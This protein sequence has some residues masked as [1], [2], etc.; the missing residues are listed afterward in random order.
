MVRGLMANRKASIGSKMTAMLLLLS[1]LASFCSCSILGDIRGDTDGSR[2]YSSE[3]SKPEG[4]QTE[5]SETTYETMEPTGTYII[6]TTEPVEV[7]VSYVQ[8]VYLTS[9]W[10]D[11]VDD[12][13]I[14]YDYINSEDAFALKGV[15]Y[16]NTPLNCVFQAY[17]YKDDE[18]LL[19]RYV[20]MND[21][22]I[23]EA[24]FSAGLEGLGTFEPG[25]YYVQL[26]LDGE[27]VASTTTMTVR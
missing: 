12:N 25:H 9:T 16:F 17:L 4:N 11:V 5:T 10:Y 27:Y 19:T 14:N 8:E 18:V 13:P 15:F 1:V 24:D 3:K 22:V 26:Y 20:K 2:T 7:D 21:K 6:E 23:A